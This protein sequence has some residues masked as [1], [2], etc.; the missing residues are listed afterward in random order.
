MDYMPRKVKNAYKSQLTNGNFSK[1]EL[2]QTA[3]QWRAKK[4]K[5]EA[6]LGLV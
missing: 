3:N 4:L 6:I 5:K 1:S 2:I